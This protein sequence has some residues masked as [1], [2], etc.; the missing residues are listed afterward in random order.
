MVLVSHDEALLGQVCDRIVEVR[1]AGGLRRGRA[2]GG[3]ER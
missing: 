3:D 2:G 1:H